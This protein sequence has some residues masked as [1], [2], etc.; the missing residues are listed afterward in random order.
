MVE[1]SAFA[2][3]TAPIID[4]PLWTHIVTPHA[5]GAVSTPLRAPIFYCDIVE[6]THPGTLRAPHTQLRHP[7]L[8][9]P[10]VIAFKQWVDHR[11]L[12]LRHRTLHHIVGSCPFPDNRGY[13]RDTA[14]R[15]IKLGLGKPGSVYIKS[16]QQR[17]GV[18]HL[19]RVTPGRRPSVSLQSRCATSGGLC[20]SRRRR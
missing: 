6:R 13:G 17:V 20:R 19:H 7:E 8:G 4:G 12:Q 14:R 1:I 9:G 16:R 2:S 18:G 11:S 10:D 3:G 5:L 15:S